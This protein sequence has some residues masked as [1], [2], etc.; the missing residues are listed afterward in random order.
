MTNDLSEAR[1][2]MSA[3]RW[4]DAMEP[5][6]RAA[7]ETGDPEALH[8]L[9]IACEKLG[10][11][12]EAVLFQTEAAKLLPERAD[13]HFALGNAHRAA[14][15][16]ASAME[17]WRTAASLDPTH[18]DALFNL[19]VAH[20]AEGD[21]SL[22]EGFYKRVAALAPTHRRAHYNLGNIA[23]RGHDFAQATA[24]FRR[25]AEVAPDFPD[26]RINL[27]L[28]QLRSG[29]FTGAVKTLRHAVALQPDNILAHLNLGQAL[30]STG[31]L[32]AG[33]RE[34]E[35][36][37]K[38]MPIRFE[39]GDAVPWR[40]EPVAGKRLLIYAEQGHGDAI[41]FLRYARALED[42]G[43]EVVA[44]THPGLVGLASQA[45]G[46][47]DA[48]PFGQTPAGIDA[49]APLMSVP[50]LLGLTDR[51]DI[52]GAPYITPAAPRRT[53]GAFRVGVVWAGNPNHQL[54][55][56]RSVPFDVFRRLFAAPGIT[57]VSLQVVDGASAADEE[58]AA[59][60]FTVPEPPLAD[61]MATADLI[62]GL[63]LV[64]SVD[65]SVAH[66]AGAIGAPCWMLLPAVADW[67]WWGDGTDT[68][69]YDSMR[70]Y[71]QRTAGDWPSVI[72]TVLADL[73]RLRRGR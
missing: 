34:T 28:A 59:G 52:D 20:A 41:Q 60:R 4:R 11:S 55:Q 24:Y 51:D 22:A 65:T 3:G 69:W 73:L 66:L 21:L 10:L 14:G 42:A 48:A 18:A 46:V 47:A 56:A 25:A 57:F 38:I 17:A 16:A 1:R 72:D 68:P 39:P 45:A 7:D 67:R 43:A 54:D 63:D 8:L 36:R 50:L 53:G 13:V 9:G 15:D 29:D 58:T 61:Y 33:W 23:F 71:R 12:T 27:G 32:E 44:L 6:R 40:G 30:L 64:I 35:W 62:A 31:D 37:R 26:A 49:H 19:A 2:L 5:C 70:L